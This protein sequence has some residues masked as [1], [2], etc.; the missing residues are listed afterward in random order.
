MASRE[1][2]EDRIFQLEE[3]LGLRN[4]ENVYNLV[5]ASSCHAPWR[6]T[7]MEADIL[8]ILLAAPAL[9]S[10]ARF[11][12]ILYGGRD[13]YPET[14]SIIVTLSKLRAKLKRHKIEIE[15]VHSVGW[16]LTQKAKAKVRALIE[17]RT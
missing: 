6:L 15:N 12:E 17:S 8:G 9:T 13:I 1:E 7:R 11:E 14:N 4:A 10:K 16:R 3:L 5:S 2:L